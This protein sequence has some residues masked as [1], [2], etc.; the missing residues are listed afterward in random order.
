MLLAS[1]DMAGNV[2]LWDFAS[3]KLLPK[4]IASQSRPITY[5]AFDHLG[6]RLAVAADEKCLRVWHIDTGRQLA[7]LELALGVPNVVRYTQDGKLLAAATSAGGLF[8]WD[9]ETYKPRAILRGE[10]NPA[11]Q[12]GHGGVIT[13]VA[14]LLT[15][16]L[17][18]GSVDKT[19]RIWDLKTRKAVAT[20]FTSTRR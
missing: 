2:R 13:C 3:R 7:I 15:D 11:G 16:K 10:G 4:Q 6:E 17:L 20:A 5:M 19:V 9:S 18:T 14:P 1:G 8:L 12:Q